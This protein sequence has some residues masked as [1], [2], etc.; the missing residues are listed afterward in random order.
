MRFHLLDNITKNKLKAVDAFFYPWK[1]S[2]FAK[3]LNAKDQAVLVKDLKKRPMKIGQARHIAVSDGQHLF[4]TVFDSFELKSLAL[5]VRQFIR[6]AKNERWENLAINLGDLISTNVATEAVIEL[7]VTECMLAHYD[8]SEKFKTE[9]KE[10]WPK[11]KSVSLF[12]G[13]AA[14]ARIALKRGLTIGE[15]VNRARTLSN[16]PP[17]EMTPEGV[18]QAALDLSAKYPELQ[19]MVFDEQRLEAMGMNAILAVGRGSA[20][21]PRLIVM[22]YRGA[23]DNSAP[24]ALVG[25]GITFDSGGLNLK[26]ADSMADMHLDMSGGASVIAAMGAIAELKLPVNVCAVIAAAENMPSGFSYRQGD[27]IKSYSGKTIEIGNTDAEGRVVLADAIAYA[28]TKHPALIV[29]LATLTGAAIVALGTRVSALFVKNNK[30]LEDIF[31]GLGTAS[32]DELWPLPLWKKHEDDVTGTFADVTNT[33]KHHSRYGGAST[34]AA[35][36]SHFSESVPL[37]HVDMAPRMLANSEEDY[38]A[39]GSAGFGVRLLIKAV[40]K[41]DAVTKALKH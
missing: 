12:R 25:K 32:M 24:L 20:N 27:I 19:V 8:F 1:Q 15:A 40:E 26:P 10:G 41:W 9:P 7:I 28:K 31:R 5:S 35:F 22:E 23:G 37:V 38:L 17:G 16:F 11:I 4:L 33:N 36:L 3:F 29:T 21:P 2:G 30:A 13:K 18:A 6:Q 34:G 14:T 39:K